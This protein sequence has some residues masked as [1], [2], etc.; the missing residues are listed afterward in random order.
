MATLVSPGVS[1]SVID[2]SFNVSS[3]PGTVP[4]IFIATAQDKLS[5]TG[6]SVAVGTTK[7]NANKLF[8]ATSQ[9]ELLQTYGM[10][11]FNVVAG[12]SQHGNPLN[13]FGLFAAHSYLGISNR[14]Y[15]VRADLDLDQLQAR[16]SAPQVPPVDGTYWLDRS[17]MVIELYERNASN[18]WV[19]KPVYKTSA[20]KT[21][22]PYGPLDVPTTYNYAITLGYSDDG[23]ENENTI[24]KRDGVD[25]D[26]LYNGTGDTQNT[27]AIDAA[28]LDI[29]YSNVWPVKRKNGSALATGDIWVRTAGLEFPVKQ[30]DATSGNFI[31]I[32]TPVFDNVDSA[33]K[34]YTN[35]MAE[36]DLFVLSNYNFIAEDDT[37]STILQH[38]VQ[39]FNGDNSITVDTTTINNGESANYTFAAVQTIE[40]IRNRYLSSSNTIDTDT[41]APFSLGIATYTGT[42]IKDAINSEL[43]SAGITDVTAKFV[44]DALVL[45][46]TSGTTSIRVNV[47]SG[48]DLFAEDTYSNWER[49]VY[50][51]GSSSP[52]GVR[53]DGTLWYSAG[54]DVDMMVKGA[55]AWGEVG[56]IYV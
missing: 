36:G 5:S 20:R 54:F 19:S 47:T 50:T 21:T 53:P 13:E 45:V 39:R 42:Q 30:Y 11:N 48:S 10:P 24:W 37:V 49:L 31:D 1:V 55:T 38:S 27:D 8:L 33:A 29:Q 14:A 4:I 32:P 3:G 51:F 17:G 2:E 34:S 6:D 56:D 40:I 46:S 15:I 26:I 18:T 25:F 44:A 9:R 52:V 43:V 12:N 7:A 16:D 28:N 35:N 41:T 23:I 22:A